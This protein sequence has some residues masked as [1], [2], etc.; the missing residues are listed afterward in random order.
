MKHPKV[1]EGRRTTFREKINK[2]E[3]EGSSVVYVDESG[4]AH[5]MPRTYGYSPVGGRCYGT[6]NCNAKGRKNVIAG[7]CGDSLIG[8]GIVEGNVDTAVFNTW[9]KKI[10]IP[11]L[12]ENSVVIMDNA[13]FHKSQETKE[14]IENH[15]HKIEFLPPYSPDLNPIEH[16]WAQAKAIRR[17]EDCDVVELF[18]DHVP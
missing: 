3:K 11:D 8:C 12:P 16:K 1:D 9:V 17:R 6:Q 15:G 13:A 5:D 14:L 7:L 2:Y 4:F 10:F 18:R